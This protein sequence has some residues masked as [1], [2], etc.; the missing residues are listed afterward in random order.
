MSSS[1]MFPQCT[2]W[3]QTSDCKGKNSPEELKN[4]ASC[5]LEITSGMS[6]YCECAPDTNVYFDCATEGRY[7]TTCNEVCGVPITPLYNGGYAQQYSGT[8]PSLPPLFGG[9]PVQ[10][11]DNSKPTINTFPYRLLSLYGATKKIALTLTADPSTK[12]VY[13]TTWDK[14]MLSSKTGYPCDLWRNIQISYKPQ[15]F[16]VQHLKTGLYLCANNETKQLTIGTITPETSSCFVFGTNWGDRG[17]F[18]ASPYQNYW[19]AAKDVNGQSAVLSGIPESEQETYGRVNQVLDFCHGEPYD[20]TWPIGGTPYLGISLIADENNHYTVTLSASEVPSTQIQTRIAGIRNDWY[21]LPQYGL[22]NSSLHPV[23]HSWSL[24]QIFAFDPASDYTAAF[25]IAR[26]GLQP[27]F[28]DSKTQTKPDQSTSHMLCVVLNDS[29][30]DVNSQGRGHFA[31]VHFKYWQYVDAV[32]YD[33][34]DQGWA[35][36]ELENLTG[37]G[38]FGVSPGFSGTLYDLFDG[39]RPGIGGRIWVPPVNMINTGHKNGVKVYG[40]IGFQEIYYGGKFAWW[41]QFVKDPVK[42]AHVLVDV[43]KHYGCDGFFINYESNGPQGPYAFAGNPDNETKPF[44]GD[45]GD[46]WCHFDPHG[47]GGP[48]NPGCNNKPCKRCVDVNITNGTEISATIRKNL[49]LMFKE[50]NAYRLAQQ[51]PNAELIWY[52]SMDKNGLINY[53]GG[54]NSNNIDMWEDADGPVADYMFTMIPGGGIVASQQT[55]TYNQSFESW[56][57]DQELKKQ[58]RFQRGGVRVAATPGLEYGWPQNTGPGASPKKCLQGEGCLCNSDSCEQTPY[59]SKMKPGRPYDFYSTINL[60]SQNDKA[61]TVTPQ[62]NQN[63]TDWAKSWYG[64]NQPNSNQDNALNPPLTSLGIFGGEKVFSEKFSQEL[65]DLKQRLM[66]VAPNGFVGNNDD[67]EWKPGMWKGLSHYFAERSV[68]FKLPFCTYF[69]TGNG[70][71]MYMGGKKLEGYG[72]WTNWL[73]DILPTWTWWPTDLTTTVKLSLAYDASYYG[74]ACIKAKVPTT[75]TSD[76]GFRLYKTKFTTAEPVRITI[77]Y[78]S[79]MPNTSDFTCGYSLNS[80]LDIS[81]PTTEFY[82]PVSQSSVGQWQ[83]V[84][85]LVDNASADDSIVMLWFNVKKDAVEQIFRLGGI[86]VDVD[87]NTNIVPS[88]YNIKVQDVQTASHAQLTSLNV[89]WDVPSMSDAIDHYN[90]YLDGLYV[91][92]VAAGGINPRAGSMDSPMIFNIQNITTS[93]YHNVSVQAVHANGNKSIPSHYNARFSIPKSTTTNGCSSTAKGAGSGLAISSYVTAAAG[94]ALAISYG[95]TKHKYTRSNSHAGFITVFILLLVAAVVMFI[96]AMT[97][98][99]SCKENPV[100]TSSMAKKSRI[101]RKPTARIVIEGKTEPL[102][103]TQAKADVSAEAKRL[104]QYALSVLKDQNLATCIELNYALTMNY[105]TL[106][107]SKGRTFAYTGGWSAEGPGPRNFSLMGGM[108]PRDSC[109][110]FHSY[111]TLA[112]TSTPVRE[113]IVGLVRQVSEQLIYDSYAN[114]FNPVPD[115]TNTWIQGHN[116]YVVTRNY[117]PDGMCYLL[118]LAYDLWKKTG[119]TA[120]FDDLFKIAADKIVVQFTIEQHRSK[121]QLPDNDAPPVQSVYRFDELENGGVGSYVADVDENGIGMTWTAFRAS[122]DQAIFGWHIPNNMFAVSALTKLSEILVSVPQYVTDQKA[123]RIQASAVQLCSSLDLALEK[124]AYYDHAEFGKIYA[125]EVDGLCNQ[126]FTASTNQT[127][128]TLKSVRGF[129]PIEEGVLTRMSCAGKMGKGSCNTATPVGDGSYKSP[130]GSVHL[131]VVV[132]DKPLAWG[133]YSVSGNN[134]ILKDAVPSGATVTIR[135]NFNLMDDA[136]IPSL[137]SIP[138]LGYKGLA[139]SDD[140][141]QNTRNFILSEQNRW[142]YGGK[143]LPSKLGYSGIGSAHTFLSAGPSMIWHMALAMQGITS[144]DPD[145]QKKMLDM[146]VQSSLVNYLNTNNPSPHFRG[147]PNQSRYYMHESF[148]MDDPNFYTRGTFGWSSAMFTE[149]FQQMYRADL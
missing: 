1:S 50:F 42:T 66:Y 117:E 21:A 92:R 122:D 62:G 136:N 45:S 34:G 67:S 51:Y 13:A 52:E 74:G 126:T 141:Y 73:Q 89:T 27:R 30:T 91:N 2:M 26:C 97:A 14:T 60:G 147:N 140:V 132:N 105:L 40:Y 130:G 139:W 24:A 121:F 15:R 115:Y 31:G 18:Y 77:T 111:L 135:G 33:A 102:L 87:S 20:P 28:K 119:E 46:Y 128:F 82:L 23:A 125:Y 3:H 70:R 25:N 79:N 131:N 146:C 86:Q 108:W 95:A 68:L 142:Y 61:E 35:A 65:C 37:T 133:T 9:T 107:P 36:P 72:Q 148:N 137:L 123:Q 96:I 78:M 19:C 80:A 106:I 57:G 39:L 110:A 127:Q 93:G 48:W 63:Q 43:C 83:K 100:V 120:H 98:K 16:V 75:H 4:N 129:T 8:P 144:S 84:T 64:G 104:G 145:E 47:E 88:V 11:S 17:I 5:T 134:V 94:I 90:I 49:L 10:Q 53:Y 71:E 81:K 85:Y 29:P 114:A 55:S 149:L 7:L 22:L 44:I 103:L 54:I 143:D 124:Y 69:N 113:M 76:V 118:W 112:Q 101:Q 109:A 32:V 59:A 41:E 6:G 99:T 116:G 12:R 138:Y 56:Q 38:G 58:S